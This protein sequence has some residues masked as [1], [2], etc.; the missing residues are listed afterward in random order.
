M[1]REGSDN[2]SV[3]AETKTS[4]L[5]ASRRNEVNCGK[6]GILIFADPLDDLSCK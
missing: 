3:Q 4:S 2:K 1:S 5:D 6:G